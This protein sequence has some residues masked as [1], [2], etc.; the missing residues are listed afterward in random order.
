MVYR[1]R[2]HG[3]CSRMIDIDL[4]ENGVIND[5]HF[6]GGCEGNLKGIRQLV[7]GRTAGE[8]I[9]MLEGIPCAGKPTSCPDQLARALKAIL[10]QGKTA[11]ASSGHETV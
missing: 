6:E 3:T 11:K 10:E 7:K 1:Y 8:L 2:T 9:S 5:I 4:A